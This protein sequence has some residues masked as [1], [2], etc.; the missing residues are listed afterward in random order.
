MPPT[1]TLAPTT[2]IHCSEECTDIVV[3]KIG[4][5]QLVGLEIE[6]SRERESESQRVR[7]RES[8]SEE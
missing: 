5:V 2:Y 1:Q 7:E 6:R 4:Q 3:R 8:E